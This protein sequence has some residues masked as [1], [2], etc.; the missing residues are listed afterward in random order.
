MKFITKNEKITDI[1]LDKKEEILLS[2]A[3]KLLAKIAGNSK[4]TV[5]YDDVVDARVHLGLLLDLFDY[6]YW[7]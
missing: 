3:Y 2:D 5:F 1:L 6:R 7:D 4:G